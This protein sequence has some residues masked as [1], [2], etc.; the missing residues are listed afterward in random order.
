M[1]ELEEMNETLNVSIIVS[2][3]EIE[4]LERA[5]G[6][7]KKK[8]K[9][10]EDLF[11]SN[12][13]VLRVQSRRNQSSKSNLFAAAQRKEKLF[14]QLKTSEELKNEAIVKVE[15]SV[16]IVRV[17]SANINVRKNKIERLE[18]KLRQLQIK[19][20]TQEDLLQVEYEMNKRGFDDNFFKT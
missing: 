19:K 11:F 2:R 12:S 9:A 14:Q 16:K 20:I 15:E 18:R 17:E 13:A 8:L 6:L 5:L 7:E 4:R 3:T 10:T 1:E